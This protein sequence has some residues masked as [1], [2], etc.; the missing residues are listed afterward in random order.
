MKSE[1]HEEKNLARKMAHEAKKVGKAEKAI[2][3]E[4]VK[5]IK[6]ELQ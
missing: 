4:V 6:K 2:A 5:D 3:D 1:V